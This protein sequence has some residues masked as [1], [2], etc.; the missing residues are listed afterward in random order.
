MV[1]LVIWGLTYP[2]SQCIHFLWRE[3][4]IQSQLF[5]C[6]RCGC[7][8]AH[9]R[10]L[11]P[12]VQSPELHR[13]AVLPLSASETCKTSHQCQNTLVPPPQKTTHVEWKIK[14]FYSQIPTQLYL[15]AMCSSRHPR[16]VMKSKRS[17]QGCG[18]SKMM[19][20][21]RPCSSNQSN[22]R[23]TPVWALPGF[24]PPPR[25]RSRAISMGTRFGSSGCNKEGNHH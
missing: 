2:R 9:S 12:C 23:M 14:L 3:H 25:R 7:P 8:R 11:C 19:R 1:L 15:W 18:L 5:W 21:P 16:S 20:N 24:G 22:I 17:W 10:L 6:F 13:T 4:Q